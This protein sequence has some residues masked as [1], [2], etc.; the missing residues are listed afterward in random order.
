MP[1]TGLFGMWGI[2]IRVTPLHTDHMQGRIE[3]VACILKHYT[4]MK[5]S[6]KGV[7]DPKNWP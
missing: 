3:L 6:Q 7:L 2:H 1:A 5:I 4:T